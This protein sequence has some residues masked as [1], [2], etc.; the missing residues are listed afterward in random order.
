[1]IRHHVASSFAW[2]QNIIN[3]VISPHIH[4][5]VPW[6]FSN[7]VFLLY[8]N[9]PN[10]AS[11]FT[12]LHKGRFKLTMDICTY[13]T[14]CILLHSLFPRTFLQTTFSLSSLFWH[15][16]TAVRLAA[17]CLLL[18]ECEPAVIFLFKSWLL[19]VWLQE[20]LTQ[21]SHK[22]P[23]P[24]L[25]THSSLPAAKQTK[26]IGYMFRQYLLWKW[27]QVKH[28]MLQS[29]IQGLL[30]HFMSNSYIWCQ[31]AIYSIIEFG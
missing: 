5:L 9:S 23:K 11:K 29:Q 14:L 3:T 30:D 28:H 7:V 22:E 21:H 19:I 15:G 20:K 25:L 10:L 17:Q 12:C 26:N 16:H 31:D 8:T 6:N 18:R 1:M 13:A 27:L 2:I 24:L 4:I